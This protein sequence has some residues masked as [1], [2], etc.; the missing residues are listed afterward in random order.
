MVKRPNQALR[1]TPARLAAFLD[2]IE[3]GGYRAAATKASKTESAYRLAVTELQAIVG[4][5]PL[6]RKAP[7]GTLVPT[8]LGRSVQQRSEQ[9]LTFGVGLTE[10]ARPTAVVSFL[11]H[12]V[13]FVARA[14]A[15]AQGRN[16]RTSVRVTD[17]QQVSI[18]IL[19]QRLRAVDM[20]D[21][22]VIG[23]LRAGTVDLA[24]GPPPDRR[25]VITADELV[26]TLLYTPRLE[27]MVARK[28][29]RE[30]LDVDDLAG[31]PLLLAPERA[32]SRSLLNN[33]V[34][35]YG[36]RQAQIHVAHEAWETDVLVVLC[37]ER[38]GTLIAGSDIACMY[39]QRNEFSGA[40]AARFKWI[41]VRL[42]NGSPI[43][44]DVNLTQG[45]GVL[46]AIVKETAEHIIDA[47]EHM[48]PDLE[49]QP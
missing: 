8:P 23:P 5:G 25:D 21:Q 30:Y 28:D 32:R 24:I 44:Y 17:D 46:S 6:L 14:M 33:A 18:Q 9:I 48:R 47:A 1:I 2:V 16:R 37:R 42:P 35:R 20:F 31:Q 49:G 3:A 36:H 10:L 38:L 15:A 19:P 43:S 12:H 11:P 41:P 39:K 4:A 27:A 40:S 26:T 34:R 22:Q 45:S 7:D 13:Q 29:A